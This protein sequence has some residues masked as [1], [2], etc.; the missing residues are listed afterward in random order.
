LKRGG[1]LESWSEIWN[2]AACFKVLG[3]YNAKAGLSRV[4]NLSFVAQSNGWVLLNDFPLRRRQRMR[5]QAM[6]EP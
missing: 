2:K 4:P 3:A 5:M 1:R 6:E